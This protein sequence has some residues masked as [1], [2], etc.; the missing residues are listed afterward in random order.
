MY[1]YMCV[2][3]L[4]GRLT[5]EFMGAVDLGGCVIFKSLYL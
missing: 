1:V 2:T 5:L 3:H 4:N